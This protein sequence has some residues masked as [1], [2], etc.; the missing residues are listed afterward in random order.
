MRRSSS[1][2]SRCGASSA[3]CAGGRASRCSDGSLRH[4][5]SLGFLL[6]VPK[7]VSS[8]LSGSS[9][10]IIA[11]RNWRTA[12]APA[13]SI[14]RERAVDAV[15]LQ[16]GELRHQRLALRGGVKKAL[17]AVVVA[18]LLHDI[19]FVEQLL[20]H[21]A[22]RLLGD[23]QHVQQIGDLEAGIAVDEMHH[24]VMG[25]AEPERLQLMVGV[26]DEI[27][28]GEE[29]QLDDVPAQIAGAGPGDAPRPPFESGSA[30]EP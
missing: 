17:P 19:A 3:G 14:S 8:T 10:S 21:P 2:S 20:E 5:H 7:I 28:I 12:S 4:G 27:A 9:R 23:A 26:A 11:R 18:G 13:G 16:P 22:E 1:T 30:A 6:P 29:Q 15:G 25:P 24:P